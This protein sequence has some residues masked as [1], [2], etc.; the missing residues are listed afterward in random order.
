M[1]SERDSERRILL[2]GIQ[3]GKSKF[4]AEVGELIILRP[5]IHEIFLSFFKLFGLKDKELK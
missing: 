4:L 3:R 2:L 1:L 5:K